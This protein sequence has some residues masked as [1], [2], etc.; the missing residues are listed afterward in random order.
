MLLPGTSAALEIRRLAACSG[1]VLRMRG[2]IHEGDYARFRS[3]VKGRGLIAGL[4]LSSDGGDLE[5]GLQIADLVHRKKL[6]VY[7]AG[8]CNSVCAMIFFSARKRYFGPQSRIGVH[9]VSDDRDI[10]DPGSMLLTVKL[11][12]LSA[13][14]G[15]PNAAIGKMVITRPRTISY[16]DQADLSALDASPGNPFHYREKPNETGQ[17]L[18]QACSTEE[19]KGVPKANDAGVLATCRHRAGVRIGEAPGCH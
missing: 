7:V 5:E 19:A 8:E 11:A 2:D 17:Q 4:D 18:Q 15:V 12:R 10:E 13:K 9:S 16:L 6:A 14:L 1:V 3:H